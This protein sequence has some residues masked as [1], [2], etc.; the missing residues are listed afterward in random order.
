MILPPSGFDVYMKCCLAYYLNLLQIAEK[1]TGRGCIEKVV[2]TTA[3]RNCCVYN[4]NHS[5]TCKL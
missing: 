1:Q 3:E 2:K 5:C 4:L